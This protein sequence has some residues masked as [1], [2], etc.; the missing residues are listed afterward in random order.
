MRSHAPS[1]RPGACDACRAGDHGGCVEPCTCYDDDWH[2]H[3]QLSYERDVGHLSQ[4]LGDLFP[5][6]DRG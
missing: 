3:D 1:D 4:T 5:G 6:G 2:W